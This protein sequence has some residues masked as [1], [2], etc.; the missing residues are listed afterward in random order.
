MIQ[1]STWLHLRL[2]FSIFLL[3]VFLLALS[4]SGEV[5]IGDALLILVILHFFLYPASNG[6]NSY[7]DKDKESIGGLR[8]PPAVLRELYFSSLVLD[9][10]AILLGLFIGWEFS[11]MLLGYGLVS[12]AYSHPAIRLKKFPF[13]GWCVAG[14]FQG[15]YTV[16]MVYSTLNNISI[17]SIFSDEKVMMAAFLS[18]LLLWGSYPMTQVYQHREDAERG[19]RTLSLILG[20]KGTFHFTA[21]VFLLADLLFIY[22]YITYYGGLFAIIFQLC[23][24]PVLVYFLQWYNSV[25]KDLSFADF[26][27]T[28]KLNWISAICLNVCFLLLRWL[29]L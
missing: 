20:I 5:S 18:T 14:L 22:F 16:V 23:L 4:I 15:W 13:I 21:I 17:Q 7:F 29:V 10:V 25:R 12:K 2:P 24:F 6:Y 8:H 11:L 9:L 3:P 26:D 1:R 19:D 28:M 27:H